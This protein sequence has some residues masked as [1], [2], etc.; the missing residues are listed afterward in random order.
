VTAA[1]IGVCTI[2]WNQ[3]DLVLRAVRSACASI[4]VRTSVVVVDNGSEPS[5]INRLLCGLTDGRLPPV[6]GTHQ[7]LPVLHR[8]HDGVDVDVVLAGDNTGFTGATN[9]AIG[10]VF[11]HLGCDYGF[12][13]NADATLEQ[14][15][16]AE[17]VACAVSNY[18][19]GLVSALILDAFD[20]SDATISFGGSHVDRFGRPVSPYRGK[21]RSALPLEGFAATELAGGAGLLI[22][23]D[24]YERF[25][26]QDNRYFFDVDD[27]E[28]SLRVHLAG[29]RNYIVYGAVVRHAMS[30]SVRGRRALSR[31]YNVR[32]LLLF[33]RQ[34][35]DHRGRWLFWLPFLLDLAK[36]V[37]V[38]AIRRDGRRL[39][40]VALAIGHH[41]RGRYGRGPS[42][43]YG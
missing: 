11:G 21:P 43:I 10:Y 15:A 37:A 19:V 30:S 24:T 1:S 39:V 7:G 40:S 13:L 6:L 34:Y 41:W 3:A 16:L 8:R 14:G 28:Y 29:H 32:N 38:C 20:S 23:R 36:E 2:N 4:G 9:T 12:L 33:H 35:R 17:L 26:G 18:R 25:G 5:S 27:A 31:Y 42:I 22:P